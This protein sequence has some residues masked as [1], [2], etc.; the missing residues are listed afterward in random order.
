MEGALVKKNY[1]QHK[2]TLHNARIQFGNLTWDEHISH[3]CQSQAADW[4]VFSAPCKISH[5]ARSLQ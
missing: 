1:Y 3:V 4:S 5:T 2:E